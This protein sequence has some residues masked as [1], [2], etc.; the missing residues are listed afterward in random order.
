MSFL[1]TADYK[2]PTNSNYLKLKEGKNIFRIMSSAIVGYEYWNTNNK[3]IRSREMFEE[4]PT[5]IQ[6]SKEGTSRISHFW[7]FVV[8][9]YDEK[10]LQILELTQ[11][12][13]METI[14]EYVDNPAWGSPTEYDFIISR[15]G[16]G[17]DTEYSVTVNPKSPAPD[18]SEDS[19]KKINLEALYTGADPFTT[20]AK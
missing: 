18:I 15:K 2:I 3:P 17:F 19:V 9:N 13:I 20:S 14:K 6:V 12:G 8:Y 5:D 10:K 7:A 1:P 11:K 4:T 16:A